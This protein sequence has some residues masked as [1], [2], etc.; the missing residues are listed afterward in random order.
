MPHAIRIHQTGG[1]EVMHW[2]E[3]DIPTPGKDEVLIRHTAIG[4]NYIDV[5]HRN[6]LY[7][8]PE[9]PFTPGLEAAGVVEEAGE[10]AEDYTPGMRVCYCKGP[11]GAYGEYRVI[12]R[13]NIIPI[14]DAIS[15]MHAAA[16]MLKGQTAHFLLRRLYIAQEG[17]TILVRAAAGGVGLFLCQWAKFMGARV[18]GTVGSEEKAAFAAENGCD[19]PIVY[20]KENV[21][22]RMLEI[23]DGEKCHVVYD[24]V[25]KATFDESLNCLMPFGTMVSFGQSSGP[26]PPVDPLVLMQKGSLFLTRPSLLHYK[27]TREEYLYGAAELFDLIMKGKMKVHVGQSYYLSDV[28]DAHRDLEAGNTRGS[29]ILLPP[30]S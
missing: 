20:T 13:E 12:H 24:S 30:S 17:T 8:V 11:L 4:V 3:T 21:E 1:P 22:E 10:G 25:G 19:F 26:V 6:G 15:D 27:R 2:E 5:Y 9:R 16:A 28:A 29:T 23:T 18:I 14:P 7:P